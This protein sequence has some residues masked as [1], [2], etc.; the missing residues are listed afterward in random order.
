MQTAAHY[1]RM[2]YTGSEF[3]LNEGEG[4]SKLSCPIPASQTDH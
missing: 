3:K 1:L 4:F 2:S